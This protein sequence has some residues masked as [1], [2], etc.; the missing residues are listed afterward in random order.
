MSDSFTH[1]LLILLL[2]ICIRNTLPDRER[3]LCMKLLLRI[4][5]KVDLFDEVFI[6]RAQEWLTA[7]E[8][9]RRR[10][11]RDRFVKSLFLYVTF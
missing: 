4:S 5:L 9:T 2:S 7:L 10:G 6:E 11:N 8:G 1:I 3:T